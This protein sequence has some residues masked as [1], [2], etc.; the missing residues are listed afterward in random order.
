MSIRFS[1]VVNDPFVEDLLRHLEHVFGNNYAHKL[2][3][4]DCARRWLELEDKT[5]PIFSRDGGHM[6][7]S[8]LSLVEDSEDAPDVSPPS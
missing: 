4:L 8:V 2:S 1:V 3:V 7:L 5:P 6:L